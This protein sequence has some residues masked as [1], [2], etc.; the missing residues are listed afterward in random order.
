MNRIFAL[1]ASAGLVGLVG[2]AYIG[3]EEHAHETGFSF[4]PA[5]SQ[6]VVQP[7]AFSH[8]IH[9]GERGI[10]C[11]YCHQFVDKADYAG[12]PPM[13]TCVSCHKG[14]NVDALKDTSMTQADKKTEIEKWLVRRGWIYAR[15]R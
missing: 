9:V 5:H 14:I 7:I 8:K 15:L 6:P 2:L 13:D 10:S 11:T 1:A 3:Y 4:G 12:I